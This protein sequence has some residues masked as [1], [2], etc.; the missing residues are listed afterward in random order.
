[1]S[2]SSLHGL[3]LASFCDDSTVTASCVL[4]LAHRDGD[5]A[6]STRQYKLSSSV[7]TYPACNTDGAPCIAEERWSATW[8][9]APSQ[10][11]YP[12]SLPSIT[13]CTCAVCGVKRG[14]TGLAEIG[15]AS[16]S[17]GKAPSA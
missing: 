8:T 15:C 12:M 5:P 7:P 14:L 10:S 6:K 9:A 1:M 13:G 17:G 11:K 4:P 3:A 16:A 2:T